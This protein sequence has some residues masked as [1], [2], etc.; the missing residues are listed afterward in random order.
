MPWVRGNRNILTMTPLLLTQREAA[1]ALAISERTLYALRKGGLI[2]AV[3]IGIGG[4]RY[5]VEELQRFIRE[6]EGCRDGVNFER[7]RERG[8][9]D[10]V[11]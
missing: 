3:R 8:E 10:S 7:Q 6:S 4:W 5:S 1:K 11:R 2:R 9:A